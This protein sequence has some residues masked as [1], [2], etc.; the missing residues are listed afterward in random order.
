MLRVLAPR[1]VVKF[2]GSVFLAYWLVYI[3]GKGVYNH[4]FRQPLCLSE[5]YGEKSWALVTGGSDGIGKGFA[6]Q[7]AKQGFNIYL[8]SRT[9]DKMKILSDEIK[10]N[11]NVDV[12]YKVKDFEKSFDDNFFEDIFEDTKDLDISILI[13]NVGMNFRKPFCDIE[14]DLIRDTIIINTIPQTIMWQ[15]FI[16][17]MMNRNKKWGIIN[18]SSFNGTRPIPPSPIYS[19]TK[20]YD[21]F[22]SRSLNYEFSNNI[23]IL[24]LRPLF[25]S[26]S[27]T[28][29][30]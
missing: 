22:L 19:A 2:T 7:L 10:Y 30:K 1:K 17:R 20:V 13:N 18:I 24:S 9:E 14:H 25:V 23:D 26:T 28:K 21:D 8:V 3:P 27:M 5:R 15:E 6:K 29:H 16:K 11:Y 4:F 12:K